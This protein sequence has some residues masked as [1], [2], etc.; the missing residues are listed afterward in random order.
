MTTFENKCAI[1][2]E[3]WLDYRYDP[4]FTDFIA[5]NDLGLPLAYAIDTDVVSATEMASKFIDETFDNFLAL[6]GVNDEGFE[7]FAG[8]MTAEPIEE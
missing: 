5:Y 6:I 7:T 4:E 2:A 3:L 1:L 8:V